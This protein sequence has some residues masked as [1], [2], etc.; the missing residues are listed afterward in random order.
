MYDALQK[1][2]EQNNMRTF[3]GIRAL[4]A[5]FMRNRCQKEERPT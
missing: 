4:P 2:S 3:F 1:Q 5:G